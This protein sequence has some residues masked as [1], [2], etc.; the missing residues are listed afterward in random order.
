ML[1]QL[2]HK[3]GAEHKMGNNMVVVKGHKL[4]VINLWK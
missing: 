2:T 1:D 4:P 3:V